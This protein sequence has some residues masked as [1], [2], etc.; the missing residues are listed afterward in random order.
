MYRQLD[1][2]FQLNATRTCLCC[3]YLIV[4][5]AADAQSGKGPARRSLKV[6]QP[7]PA[8]SPSSTVDEEKP[9]KK[10]TEDKHIHQV[11]KAASAAAAPTPAPP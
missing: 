6:V 11:A 3:V 10:K 4:L 5:G 1:I 8:N 7:T 9:S 2:V